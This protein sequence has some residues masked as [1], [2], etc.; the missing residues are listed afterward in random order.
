MKRIGSCTALLVVLSSFLAACGE[1]STASLTTNSTAAITTAKISTSPTTVSNTTLA[2]TNI[3][4]SPTTMAVV[5]TSTSSTQSAV[6]NAGTGKDWLQFNL[7]PQHNGN[8]NQET[9]LNP[10]NVGGLQQIFQ[11][12]L[13]G[14]A[15][16]APIYL[17]GVNTASGS[18]DILFVTT[19]AG[20][21]VGLDAHNG[22]QIWVQH[23]P[24][25]SC[26]IN[27]GGATCYTTSSPALDPNR[28][29]VYSY[30][31]DGF[32]H[33]YKVEDGQEVKNG[34]WP[35]LTSTKPFQEKGSSALTTATAK[36]GKSYLYVAHAGYPGDR[37][38]YQ[39]HLTTINLADGSQHVFNTVCSNQTD[40]HFVQEPGNPDC[41]Q[42][43]TAIWSR[44]SVIYDADTDKIYMTTGNGDFR[45][46]DFAWGDTVFALHPD[47]TGTANGNPL[48]TYTPTNFQQL[49][50]RDADIGSTA[51]AILPTPANSKVKQLGVQG[52]K[53]S[54]L[55]LLDL[56]NLSGKS[57]IGNIGG[58]IGNVVGVPQGGGVLTT[59]AVWLNP[60]DNTTWV[61]VANNSGISGL[62]LEVDNSGI[63]NLQVGW[64]VSGQGGT[65]PVIANGVLYYADS[66]KITAL[67]PTNGKQLWRST[68]IGEIHWESPIIINGTLYITDNSGQLTAFGLK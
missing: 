45:P 49:E 53:D 37:G 34:G 18:K 30:G 2:A 35:E 13:T 4:A 36:N 60:A 55:R 56:A 29:Y 7:N 26:K 21:I 19:R 39:G 20:D 23:N 41:S 16:G 47:G 59:P 17:S 64:L 25:G 9:R 12:Q 6:A 51:P 52:G 61:Y 44:P 14:T 46:K 38:D 63:P 43:Q 3:N 33:K 67:D 66:G 5:T 8:N 1:T 22:L 50:D 31:L 27:N 10:A 68:H 54:K 28:Q 42:K 15:D 65:S 58:E 57:E 11:V 32:V 48:D 24:A 40:V 62:K